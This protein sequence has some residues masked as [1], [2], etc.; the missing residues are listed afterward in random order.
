MEKT[1]KKP[2]SQIWVSMSQETQNSVT[3]PQVPSSRVE[4]FYIQTF[5]GLPALPNNNTETSY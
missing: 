3:L 2:H 5:S 1:N 4:E